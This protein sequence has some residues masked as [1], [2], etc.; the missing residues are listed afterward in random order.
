MVYVLV[1]LG[2]YRNVSYTYLYVR[3]IFRF[4]RSRQFKAQSV[5]ALRR[6]TGVYKPC[7]LEYIHGRW[8]QYWAVNTQNTNVNSIRFYNIYIQRGRTAKPKHSILQKYNH[9]MQCLLHYTNILHIRALSVNLLCSLSSHVS[10]KQFVLVYSF[11]W[12]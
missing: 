3:A 2:H 8:T 6:G 7:S 12:S 1:D 9:P 5:V 10:D 11:S 4:A